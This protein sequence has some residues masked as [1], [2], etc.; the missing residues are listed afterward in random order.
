MHLWSQN[1]PIILGFDS[2]NSSHFIIT[3]DRLI[4]VKNTRV[5]SDALLVERIDGLRLIYMRNL[6]TGS[7]AVALA[8]RFI[9]L[10]LLAPPPWK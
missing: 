5:A 3:R 4:I 2:K 9:I 7:I 1:S 10:T 6:L 8:A